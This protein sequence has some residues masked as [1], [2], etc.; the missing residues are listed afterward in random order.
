[1]KRILVFTF[2]LCVLWVT[3]ADAQLQTTGP[4][5][6]ES[7]LVSGAA[8]GK[9]G[10][11]SVYKG[12]PYAAPPVGKLR[13]RPPRPPTPWDGVRDATT[14]GPVAPQRP[15]KFGGV[16]KDADMSEDCLYLNVW[17]PARS[18]EEKLPVMVWIH[19][20]GF[21]YGAG[22]VDLYNGTRLAQAGVVLVTFNY[23]LNVFGSF[24]HP[25]LTE[26]SE[27]KASGNYGLMDQIAALTW[28]HNNIAAFGGDPDRVTI[29]GESAGGR[30]VSLLM[31]SPLSEGLFHRGIAQSGA[32]RDTTD[33][34][35]TREERGRE[36]AK[37]LG[38]DKESDPL[39]S[40]RSKTYEE[41]IGQE[42][43]DWSPFV[44]GWVVPDNPE[45][46]YAQGKIHDV[47]LIAGGNT[48]EGTYRLVREP[49]P[50]A[51]EYKAYVRGLFGEGADQVLALYPAEKDGDVYD[52]LNHLESDYRIALHARNQVRWAQNVSA[53]AYLYHFSRVPPSILGWK[54]GAH[55]GA[56]LRYVFGNLDFSLKD[57]FIARKVDRHLSAAMVSYW[58]Q[59]AAT[60][61]PNGGGLPEWPAYE[62]ETDMHLELGNVIAAGANLRK[63]ELD[64][65]E[66]IIYGK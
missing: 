2:V 54:L 12:I 33:S 6:I 22:S 18:A 47:P 4:V 44:D 10:T 27:H 16:S 49:I 20:G 55:H 34:L 14:F 63:K 11:I 43:L 29:F 60:G 5:K 36:T 57:F 58:T 64:V 21:R 25:L 24:A 45:I 61:D 17:T 38:C 39:A 40:L 26:E 51:S 9:D 1:M 66:A 32:L 50:S 8:T 53:K 31:V 35:A 3:S 37:A 46:L 65:L 28:I 19:G 30:S 52:A 41:L 48:D 62:P 56:E 7:G 23:R 59:F 13:W 15:T 42:R